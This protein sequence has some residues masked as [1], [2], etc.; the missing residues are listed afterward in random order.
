MGSAHKQVGGQR[1]VRRSLE[2]GSWVGLIFHCFSYD[3]DCMENGENRNIGLST[4]KQSYRGLN[5]AEVWQTGKR[6]AWL[7]VRPLWGESERE[8]RGV[9]LQQEV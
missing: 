2:Q 6:Q 4:G 5:P 1:W 8:G 7:R 3:H 9:W